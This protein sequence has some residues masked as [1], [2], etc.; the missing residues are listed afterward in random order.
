MYYGGIEA[1]GTKFICAISN[2]QF[3]IIEKVSIPTTTPAETLNQV[4]AFFDHYSLKSIGIGTFGPIDV[5][6]DSETYGFITTT[7]KQGWSQFNFLGEVKKRYNIPVAWTTD[8]NAAAYGEYK[9]GSAMEKN[10]CLYLTVGTGIGGGAIVNGHILDGFGHTEMGHI[11]IRQHP[12]DHYKGKCPYHHNCLEGL[13][14]GPSIEER[15]GKKGFELESDEK[16]WEMES[17]YLAQALVDFTLILRPEKI[18]LGGGVMKQKQLF[19]LIRKAFNKLI[20]NYVTTPELDDYIVS[21]GLGD[22]AGIMGCLLLG[23]DTK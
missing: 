13:A 7:P 11:L 19:P 17:Y 23:A 10:S 8:V 18:I 2:E 3:E 21:P 12:E 14:A 1:G 6:K 5:N 20:N 9:K 22:E 16:V 4:F 15:Y